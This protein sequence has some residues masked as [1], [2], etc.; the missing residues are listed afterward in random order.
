MNGTIQIECDGISMKTKITL[1][2]F[3]STFATLR[4]DEKSV[5]ITLLGFTSYWDYKLTNAIQ[6][7]FPGVYTSD[8]I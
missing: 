8:K 4:F 3:G 2:R 7:D 6:A 1:T 5:F